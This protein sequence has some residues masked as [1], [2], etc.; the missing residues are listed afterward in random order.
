MFIAYWR[1]DVT[2]DK[3]KVSRAQHWQHIMARH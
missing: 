1:K 2:G 3:E